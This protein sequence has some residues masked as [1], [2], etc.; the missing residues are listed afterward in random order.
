MTNEFTA[1]CNYYYLLTTL[2]ADVAAYT[3]TTCL[4]MPRCTRGKP[5]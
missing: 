2:F 5:G 3:S 1:W 4:T